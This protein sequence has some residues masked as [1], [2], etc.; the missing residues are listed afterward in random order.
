VAVE[1]IAGAAGI[2]ARSFHRCFPAKEDPVTVTS[3]SWLLTNLGSDGDTC[4]RR[5]AVR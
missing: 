1:R 5:A 3:K 2:S 4:G